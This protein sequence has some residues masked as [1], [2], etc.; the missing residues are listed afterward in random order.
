MIY[1]NN[2]YKNNITI[3]HNGT[4]SRFGISGNLTQYSTQSQNK[5]KNL[6][7]TDKIKVIMNENYPNQ[8]NKITDF[9]YLE[10]KNKN[11]NIYKNNSYVDNNN[12][13]I[14]LTYLKYWLSNLGLLDYLN[15]FIQ[16]EA[17]DIN[18]LVER[19]KSY[20][21]KIHFEDLESSLKIR[22]PGYNYR[23]LCK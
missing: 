2:S 17:Y 16:C 13:N 20:Q 21:T 5:K 3:V 14:N 4:D 15:N 10:N 9:N 7:S 18:V 11:Q 12:I 19:M 23:I 1:Q 22:I 6:F 8:T